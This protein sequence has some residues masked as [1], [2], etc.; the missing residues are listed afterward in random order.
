MVRNF[1]K[2]SLHGSD[3]TSTLMPGLAFSNSASWL[4]RNS[5]R[6][7]LVITSTSCNVE[8]ANAVPVLKAAK[9]APSRIDR[10]SFFIG[11]S[12][13]L[14]TRCEGL[15]QIGPEEFRILEPDM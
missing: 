7:G 8:S 15:L 6:C 13:G 11:T 10:V 2:A 4:F 3:T 5:V 12:L 14:H 1:S 9:A